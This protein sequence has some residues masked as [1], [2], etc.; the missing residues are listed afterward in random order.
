MHLFNKFIS[1]IIFTFL[2][3]ISLRAEYL[4]ANE[5]DINSIMIGHLYP[6]MKD[7]KI[8]SDLFA[9]IKKLNPDYVFVLGD[10]NLN[11]SKIIQNWK[12]NFGK[13]VYFVPG[14][15]EVI[16]GNLNEFKKNV[17]YL[18]KKVETQYVNFFL[19]NSNDNVQNINK[20]II[21]NLTN[22]NDKS[23]I[24]L[25]HHR[26]WDDTLTSSKPFE[27]NKSFYF[28][29]I[30]PYINSKIHSI[31]S[32][33]SKHQYF[34]DQIPTSG[35]QNMNNIFWLDRVGNINSYSIG[36]GLGKPKLGFIQVISTKKYPT[37]IIPHHISIG[38]DDPLPIYSLQIDPKSNPPNKEYDKNLK[39]IKY[40]ISKKFKKVRPYF[41]RLFYVIIGF[42][43]SLIN[44]KIKLLRNK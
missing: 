30:Y 4:S 33:D 15:N 36:T 24:I 21:N 29:E 44:S 19:I 40:Q 41:S 43:L 14:N 25:S 42:L 34:F 13:K 32:G 31:F 28:K 27:H 12:E 18:Q 37:I 16:D 5:K 17:G 23:N 1:S 39:G 6:I 2:A 35:K 9:K 11:D 10:S 38:I 7:K 3:F 26:I 20:F 22:N 8:V